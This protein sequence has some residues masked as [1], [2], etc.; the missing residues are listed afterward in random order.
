[1]KL[2]KLVLPL[3]GLAA[4]TTLAACSN[5][6]STGTSSNP[7][8]IQ[9]SVTEDTTITFWHAM[10]GSSLKTLEKMTKDFEAAH[11]K[12]HV[13]LES[14]SSYPSLQ[15]KLTSTMQSPKNLPTL[16][17]AYPGWLYN[18]SKSDMLVDQ[19][20]F[21]SNSEIGI[22]GDESI[23]APLLKGA[24][25]DGKQ[26]GIP[27]NKSTEVLYYNKTLLDEYGI[28]VPT[29]KDELKEA[30]QKVWKKSN[31]T[32]VGAGFDSLNNYY[33]IS[34]KDSGKEFNK[35]L[36]FTGSESQSTINYYFNGIKEGYFRI[37]GSDQYLNAPFDSKK[38]AFFVG[39]SVGESYLN[40]GIDFEYGVA[41][42]PTKNNVQQGTDIYMF[43]SADKNQQT[44]AY[45][46]EKFLVS[47]KEQVYWATQTG[48]MPVTNAGLTAKEYTESKTSK[49]PAII[50]ETTKH[51]FPL[52]IADNSD[53]AYSQ[54]TASMQAILSNPKGNLDDLMDAQAKQLKSVWNQ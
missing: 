47:T 11:P 14:Q 51:L 13:K 50:E 9:T 1:M 25:L 8:S 45:L 52:P 3:V 44:A 21:L 30:A 41:A 26:Y 33:S 40:K 34:M 19:A 53:A 15:A 36:D 20:N 2:K 18:A 4:V 38:L 24:Q 48:Y 17:Q 27:F 16:T 6:K 31:H 37:A 54:L 49:V 28:K 35:E 7:S 10:T 43:S 39:S 29:T 42:R 32:I 22:S 12:I 5:S 23:Q 46:Y